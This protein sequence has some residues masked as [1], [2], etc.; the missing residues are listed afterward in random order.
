MVPIP[1]WNRQLLTLWCHEILWFPFI[2]DKS[3]T[4]LWCIWFRPSTYC[5]FIFW[6]WI[7]RFRHLFTHTLLL[8]FM[9]FSNCELLCVVFINPLFLAFTVIF[10]KP[11]HLWTNYPKWCN[12]FV[13]ALVRIILFLQTTMIIILCSLASPLLKE[14]TC[15]LNL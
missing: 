13:S 15:T 5:S 9:K 6:L 2:N 4:V 10:F 7:W 8:L 14:L 12:H 3:I 11:N 1:K